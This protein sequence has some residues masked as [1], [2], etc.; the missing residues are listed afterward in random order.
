MDRA[1]KES[2]S[3][4]LDVHELPDVTPGDTSEKL[5]NEWDRRG[6]ARIGKKQELR[7]EFHFFS[8][9][10]YAMILGCSWEFALINVVLTLSNGGTA[11]TIYML[12][13]AIC[14][15]FF[16]CLSMA[17]MASIAPT[18]GGQYH[19]FSPAGYPL[20]Y[21]PVAPRKYQK[22][23]SF[24][25]GFFC[26]LGWQTSLAATCFASA[27][28]ITALISLGNPSYEPSEWQ[29]ALLSWAILLLAIFANTVLF[30][31]LPLIEGIVTFIHVLGF[32]TFVIVLWTMAP[33]G[34]ASSVFTE[35]ESNGWPTTGLA[36]LVGLNGPL[37]Y[38][39]G[40][41]SSVHLAEEL[42]NSAWRLPRSMLLTAIT[43]YITSF[44]IVVTLMFCLGDIESVVQSPTGQPYI[45]VVLNATNSVPATKFFAV[46][47]LILVTSCSVNGVTTTSRQ[48]WSFARD[49]GLPYSSW[50]SQVRPGLDVPVN[51]MAVSMVFTICLT[52]IAIGSQVAY[53]IFV[54]LNASGLLTSYIICIA[55]I[56]Q[57]RLRGETLPASRFNL[58]K[59]GNA[60]NII[61][62]C[63]LTVFW[64]FQF[65]PAAPSPAPSEMNWSCVIW[66]SVLVFFMTY[67]AF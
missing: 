56:L 54:S 52:S 63:F 8:I 51:A 3:T 35:F 5:G 7:R 30:R 60:V 53:G 27:Q 59:A 49:G 40:A 15:V 38:L 1:G 57:K 37:P 23:L 12:L 18:A 67:Y 9:T 2:I 25:V 39:T 41:D 47:I 31:K 4:Q 50:L 62:L 45:A 46:I 55:C 20:H 34:T 43:N 26:V 42:K 13:V 28:Q 16:V 58:G 48:L 6:M 66:T 61:A 65:F 44:I 24:S 64:L 17:E 14:G 11:G 21:T 22:I 19:C 32:F 10:G 33:R 29:N 36:C